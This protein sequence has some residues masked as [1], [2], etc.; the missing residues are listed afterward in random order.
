MPF[1]V[2]VNQM[3]DRRMKKI[4]IPKRSER[5]KLIKGKKKHFHEFIM[6]AE[7]EKM[8]KDRLTEKL[9]ISVIAFIWLFVG[10]F[11]KTVYCTLWGIP[12][13]IV[14]LFIGVWIL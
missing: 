1:A 2:K 9:L 3:R 4:K 11:G 10:M 7:L 14:T 8:V 13:A 5:W 6:L 12:L